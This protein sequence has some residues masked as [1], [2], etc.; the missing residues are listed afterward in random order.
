MVQLR[1]SAESPR[2]PIPTIDRAGAGQMAVSSSKA[3]PENQPRATWRA[4]VDEDE[5]GAV[6]S[7]IT[8]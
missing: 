4:S 6:C 5:D 1:L 3:F 7:S 2:P 8:Q